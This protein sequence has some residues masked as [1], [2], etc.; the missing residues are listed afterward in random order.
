[1]RPRLLASSAILTAGVFLA[2]GLGLVFHLVAA[3]GLGPVDY[4]AFTASLTYVA[5]WAVLMEGGISLALTREAAAEPA[6]LAWAPR[7]LGWKIRLG[8][9]GAGGAVASAWLLGF[10]RRIVLLIAVMALGM[11]AL[12]AMRLA[13][14]VFRVAGWFSSEATL[15]VFQ[16]AAL[17]VLALGALGLGG[18]AGGVAVA[19][20]LSYV[21]AV[22]LALGRAASA[23]RPA[24]AAPPAPPSARFL[25]WT[26]LPLLAI[27]L[28]TGLYF[29]L[30]QVLLLRLRGPEETGLYAAAYRV[31]E[32]LL[33]AVGGTMTVLFPRLAASSRA[34]PD[35]FAAD[36]G[37]AWRTLWI[38]GLALSANGWLWAV[39]L[40]PLVFGDAYAAAT[41]PLVIL[42][43]AI[44]I[45]YV[46]YLLTQSLIAAG[47]ERFY[48]LG[49]AAC[50]GLN[51]GLNLVLIPAWGPAGAA[52]ATVAT[53]G[54]LLGICVLGLGPSTRLIPVAPTI[55][56]GAITAI[57][58][59]AGWHAFADH[60]VTRGLLAVLFSVVDWEL[61]APWPLRRLLV[62]ERARRP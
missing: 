25:L 32:A 8:V 23:V 51:L 27:D 2:A 47:R 49:T 19:F 46:N 1:M 40:F 48:A 44:P 38:A 41:S 42:L 61:M 24:L 3:R 55:L 52:W 39:G 6:R 58:V 13:F 30:D 20:T 54:A 16:K 7:L 14:A 29:K 28:F 4:G 36:F 59:A 22:V 53:E 5:L 17:L 26:C 34:A 18:G 45:A 10:D 9:A 62:S 37:R 60:P 57:V 21:A 43:G 56:T 15:S 31:I 12:T 33:L 50:V 11:I 35:A